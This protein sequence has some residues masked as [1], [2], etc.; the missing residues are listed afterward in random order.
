LKQRQHGISHKLADA[1]SNQGQYLL[2]RFGA[3]LEWTW[4][5]FSFLSLLVNLSQDSLSRRRHRNRSC[6]SN[7]YDFYVSV[8]HV[9]LDST[10]KYYKKHSFPKKHSILLGPFDKSFFGLIFL[11]DPSITFREAHLPDNG[12]DANL[13]YFNDRAEV[14]VN[15]IW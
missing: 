8:V 5:D 6:C 13:L 10:E 4:A 1:D 9:R 3:I 12:D 14:V 7:W 15:E 2:K 11:K